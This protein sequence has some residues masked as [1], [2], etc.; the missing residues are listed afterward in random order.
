M[1]LKQSA[2]ILAFLSIFF[3]ANSQSVRISGFVRDS[4]NGEKIVGAYILSGDN[5]HGTVSDNEGYFSVS[6][7]PGI[8]NLTVSYIGYSSKQISITSKKDTSI[9]VTLIQGLQLDE[10]K[11]VSSKSESVRLRNFGVT[12]IP[13]KQIKLSPAMLGEVDV[14]KT[15]QMLPGVNS[16]WAGFSGLIVRGGNQDQNLILIDDIPLYSYSHFYGLFSVINESAL[17]SVR[18]MKGAMPARYGG[19]LSSIVDITLKEGNKYKRQREI[20]I[21]LMSSNIIIEG[22][23]KN[24]TTYSL[25]ARRSMYDLLLLPYNLIAKKPR[26]GFYFGDLSGKVTHNFSQRDKLT[27]SFFTSKDKYFNVTKSLEYTNNGISGTMNRDEGYK[28]GNNIISAKWN[29]ILKPSL[30]FSSSMYVSKFYLDRH[31]YDKFKEGENT[32]RSELSFTSLIN[33]F[34]TRTDWQYIPKSSNRLYFGLSSTL[35]RFKPG[36]SVFYDKNIE[37]GETIFLS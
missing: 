23:I 1:N 21:G 4:L 30:T 5:K 28:W 31:S 2:L 25:A 8:T 19:R 17:Q 37:T 11:I 16:T 20:G 12:D 3:T 26:T 18:F 10:V 24:K 32:Y 35:H 29:K 14:L 7:M 9:F 22:P 27:I 6:L 33:D 13:I 15:I 36:Q 34:G